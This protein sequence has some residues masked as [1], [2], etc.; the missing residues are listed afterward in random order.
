M[1]DCNHTCSSV[2]DN[3]GTFWLVNN[4]LVNTDNPNFNINT[5]TSDGVTTLT[6]SFL[7]SLQQNGVS[8]VCRFNPGDNSSYNSSLTLTVTA[9]N[10]FFVTVVLILCLN[11]FDVLIK[12][13]TDQNGPTSMSPTTKPSGGTKGMSASILTTFFEVYLILLLLVVI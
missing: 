7:A 4:T 6:I 8:V 10:Y 3:S 2:G 9:G 1:I 13:N 5:S 12:V 11:R